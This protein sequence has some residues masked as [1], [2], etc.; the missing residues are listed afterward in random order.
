M[1]IM[2]DIFVVAQQ[3][4]EFLH[5]FL[6]KLDP[7]QHYFISSF[8][9]VSKVILDESFHLYDVCEDKR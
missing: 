2:R 6:L 4:N 1:F 8:L 3:R 7:R 5:K 9:A